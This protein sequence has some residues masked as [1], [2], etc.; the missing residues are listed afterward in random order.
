MKRV[1]C[2]KTAKPKTLTRECLFCMER[3]VCDHEAL[4]NK[5]IL[6]LI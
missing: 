6:T 5:E 3:A 2:R 1:V 4:V